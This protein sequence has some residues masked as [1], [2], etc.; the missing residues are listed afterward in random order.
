MDGKQ[1]TQGRFVS[2]RV[3]ILAG[4]TLTLSL[5][6]VG[7]FG[8]FYTYSTRTFF[9]KL[10][11]DMVNTLNGAIEGMDVEEFKK[12]AA[13]AREGRD[14]DAAY[15]QHIRWLE[16]IHRLEPRAYP[17]TYIKGGRPDEI[18]FVGDILVVTNPDRAAKLGESYTSAEMLAP[19]GFTELTFRMTPY[20]DKWGSWVS[21]YAPITDSKGEKVGALGIDCRADYVYTEQREIATGIAVGFLVAYALLFAV[22]WFAA[23]ILTRPILRLS[24]AAVAVEHDW[25]FDLSDIADV[26]AGCDEVAHLGRVFGAMVMA[27]RQ[28]FANVEALVVERTAELTKANEQLQQ[29]VAER[30]RAEEELQ[31]R[32]ELQR[33]IS[34]L[35]TRFINLAP[36]DVDGEITRALQAIGEYAGVDRSYVCLFSG[37]GTKMTSTHE[38]CAAGV[39]PQIDNL[40][41]VP[42]ATLPQIMEKLNRLETLYVPRVADFAPDGDAEKE[43]LQ[44]Q[45]IRS[46]ILVPMVYG[47]SLMGFLG[48][49]SVRA[50]KSWSEEAIVLLRIVG[51]IFVNALE[52]RQIEEVIR[53]FNV[54]LEQ[55]VIER[56]AELQ[57]SEQKF[58]NIIEQSLDGILL[59]DERGHLIEWN[60]SMEQITGLKQA[61]VMSRPIWDIPPQMVTEER[62]G[63]VG[64][65]QITDS[66]SQYFRTGQAPW[67]S[68]P[69]EVD[70]QHVDGTLRVIQMLPFPIETDKGFMLGVTTR[71]ITRRKLAE[72]TLKR[73]IEQLAALNR[74][75]QAMTAS[76]EL[77]QVLAEIVSLAG[78]V[79]ASDYSSVAIVDGEGN[80]VQSI[81]TVPGVPPIERRA[82]PEG[83]TR[84]I[85]RS[86][87]EVA[88]DAVAEDGAII[89]QVPEGAPG[90]INPCIVAAGVKS[91]VGL[92]L[93]FRDHLLGVLYLHSL[94]PGNFHGQLPLL[95]T[96]ANQ[97]AIAIE[98][99]RLFEVERAAREQAEKLREVTAVLAST[100]DL[101][102]VLDTILVSL[103]QVIPYDGASV[104]L[105]EGEWL[106]VVTV[107]GSPAPE[108]AVGQRHPADDSLFQEI[109]RSGSSLVLADVRADPNF[110]RW[111]GTDYVRSWMGVP[112]MVGG[113]IIGCLTLDSRRAGAY[114]QKDADLGQSFANQAATAIRNAQLFEQIRAGRE[115]LQALSRRLVEVQEG[116]RGYIAREL[117]DEMGQALS[118]LV[119]GLCLL[120]READHPEA[121]VA[122]VA[123]LKSMTKSMSESLHRLA[124]DLR[125]ASLDRLG[126]VAALRHYLETFGR[127][128]HLAVRFETVDLDDGRLPPQ[129][130]ASLYRIVQEALTNVMRH[131]QASRVS[132]LLKR[133]GDQ[134][135]L[136]LED[137]G[138]GFDPET[139][140]Q[141][142]RL[143]LLGIRERVEA[144]S[145]TLVVESAVGAGTTVFVE[146]PHDSYSDS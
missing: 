61:E 111:G 94:R 131:A 18:L 97:V 56:T 144:L 122:R 26:T 132:V 138:V 7:V 84:W 119:V 126:L 103:E 39:R 62:R 83:L 70:I 141:S 130:E 135:V 60:C 67:L 127:Q 10:Q 133:R 48:F 87:Q 73:V 136:I 63:Q 15:W 24:E 69:L 19:R 145:G 91:F 20:T 113:E 53:R 100:L 43:L 44:A 123:E 42:A 72:G 140:A 46:F 115:Q 59:A 9:N 81:E 125:P 146:V 27:L 23:N 57:E 102:Q 17:Y 2:L 35:S 120:E 96:F 12:L 80:L 45:D 99:A 114:S 107:R 106:R 22:L 77:Q 6:F 33:L 101:N 105:Q 142:G 16:T 4:L 32:V 49:D 74:A 112:L 90:T 129:V 86:R 128:H 98:N 137:D 75:S 51:E 58:R 30:K 41:D 143:G 1:V 79:T 13:D 110:K 5:V 50:E 108:Q 64:Y 55:R 31:Y 118:S 47:R 40:K 76:L 66:M 25:S 3:K 38:W 117:H 68:Q 109:R 28:R 104:L 88:V 21:V 78:G 34:T 29:E 134:V 37:G 71:D 52:R 124:T 95:S 93:L 116:E 121:I 139:A 11:V 14:G 36:A 89:S 85:V 92:P 8:W 65:E 82:R 54:E